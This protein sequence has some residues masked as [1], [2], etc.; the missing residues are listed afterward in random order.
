MVTIGKALDLISQIQTAKT[1][2]DAEAQAKAS[3]LLVI[4]AQFH[5]AQ[6][7]CELDPTNEEKLQTLNAFTP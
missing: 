1:Q 6:L 5:D 7:A 4:T 3:K 2:G